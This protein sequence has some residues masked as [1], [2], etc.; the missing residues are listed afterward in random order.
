MRTRPVACLCPVTLLR[1]APVALARDLGSWRDVD[2]I[3]LCSYPRPAELITRL[4][5]YRTVPPAFY[6]LSNYFV[7]NGAKSASN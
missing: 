2:H 5:G 3:A 6:C 1:P 4:A 7:L